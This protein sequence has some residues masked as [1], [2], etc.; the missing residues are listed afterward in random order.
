MFK[1]FELWFLKRHRTKF[2]GNMFKIRG[3]YFYVD[4]WGHLWKLGPT[5]LHD[6][7]FVITLENR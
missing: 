1:W 5:Y 2:A 6:M 4:V 7:P 3:E